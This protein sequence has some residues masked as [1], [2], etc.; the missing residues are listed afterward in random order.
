MISFLLESVGK[1][2]LSVCSA[3]DI[4]KVPLNQPSHLLDVK[5]E[6]PES[7][8][9][10]NRLYLDT[11]DLYCSLSNFTVDSNTIDASYRIGK[12]ICREIIKTTE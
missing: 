5:S 1:L 11:F 3:E 10:S 12:T 6:E 8:F 7:K 9:D 2:F 4:L